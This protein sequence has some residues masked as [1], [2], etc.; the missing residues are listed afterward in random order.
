MAIARGEVVTDAITIRPV[1]GLGNQLFIYAAGR[2]VAERL[3]C[4]LLIDPSHYFFPHPHETPRTFLLDWLVDQAS[5][6]PPRRPTPAERV[7][8]RL[9]QRIP[10]L[11]ARNVFHESGF[12]YDQRIK[13]VRPGTLLLGY[14][15]S[16][17]YFAEIEDLLRDTLLSQ[18]PR[19]EWSERESSLLRA[20]GPWTGVHVRR[21][22]YLDPR[23]ARYHGVL[24]TGYYKRA[25]RAIPG[26]NSL[27]LVLFSD[28]VP[29]AQEVVERAHPIEH[30]VDPPRTAHPMETLLLMSQ[31][32]SLIIA[33]SSFSWWGAWLAGKRNIPVIV[34]Q[35]W[36]TSEAQ[37]TNDLCPHSWTMVPARLLSDDPTR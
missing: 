11:S 15:Q 8:H 28:D 27:P 26:S 1:G 17:R 2:A 12:G 20:L 13:R 37:T 35:P 10:L 4:P 3:D 22:D 33:N 18:S 36:F 25:L 30:L 14:F 19:S 7:R 29:T 6:I 32:S 34:P 16:W 5:I 24:T 31:S 9:E 21:G 23:N